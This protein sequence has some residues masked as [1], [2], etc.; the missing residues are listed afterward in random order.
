MHLTN[1]G[2]AITLMPKSG[3]YNQEEERKTQKS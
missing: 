2:K 3:G 1:P